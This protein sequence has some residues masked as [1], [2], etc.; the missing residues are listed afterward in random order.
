MT[1][2]EIREWLEKISQDVRAAGDSP[3]VRLSM[4]GVDQMPVTLADELWLVAQC[5]EVGEET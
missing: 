3:L 1:N 5:I 4:E 2:I